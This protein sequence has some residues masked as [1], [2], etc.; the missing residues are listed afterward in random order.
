MSSYLAHG[1]S[2]HHCADHI[3]LYL[4]FSFNPGEALA[5][6]NSTLRM[7]INC[8]LGNKGRLNPNNIKVLL[9]SGSSAQL[10]AIQPL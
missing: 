5:I 1:L 7:V 10:C 8:M 3:Q 2:Y 6:L 9:L 4:S